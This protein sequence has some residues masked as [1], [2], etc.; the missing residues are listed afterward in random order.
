MFYVFAYHS[1]Y[2]Y[3]GMNDLK[4]KVSTAEEAIA[5][6]RELFDEYGNVHIHEIDLSDG[7]L[8][9]RAIYVDWWDEV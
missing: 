2:P 9:D 5:V 3:G 1:Y 7:F 6:G 8:V 4:R